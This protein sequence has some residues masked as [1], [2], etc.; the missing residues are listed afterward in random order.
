[1]WVE[2]SDHET[3]TALMSYGNDNLWNLWFVDD[4]TEFQVSFRGT[5]NTFSISPFSA[6]QIKVLCLQCVKGSTVNALVT[7]RRL[8]QI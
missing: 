3:D 1:M 7:K 4:S 2:T 6:G 5:A 8:L